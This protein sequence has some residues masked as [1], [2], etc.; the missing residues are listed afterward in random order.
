M[1]EQGLGLTDVWFSTLT[2]QLHVNF[3]NVYQE[4]HVA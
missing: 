1:E 4:N 2:T 3:I